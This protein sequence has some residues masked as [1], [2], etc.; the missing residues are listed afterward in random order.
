MIFLGVVA[1]GVG[2]SMLFGS[3]VEIGGPMQGRTAPEVAMTGFDGGEW[4]LSEHLAVDG[5][6][7]VLN[8]W[9]SWCKPCEEEIPELS[10]FAVAHPD[11]AVVGV[12]IRD[13]FEAAKALIDRL[14]PDYLTGFD[15]TG[16]L[17]DMYVGFGMPA[18]FFI[19]SQGIVSRQIDGPLTAE[20]L[21]SIIDG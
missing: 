1:G 9:A 10:R 12:A 15:A 13:E 16:R 6:P 8:L 4:R 5:R 17:R 21:E 3:D 11:V 19:D 18:T 2:L 14:Q 7:V 20:D